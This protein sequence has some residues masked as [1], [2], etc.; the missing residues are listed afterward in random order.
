MYSWRKTT[1]GWSQMNTKLILK[2]L[3]NS[4]A[5]VEMKLNRAEISPLVVSSV[6]VGD[7]CS[8]KFPLDNK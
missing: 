6:A 7:A 2:K 4:I 3:N 8:A 1:P 5:E